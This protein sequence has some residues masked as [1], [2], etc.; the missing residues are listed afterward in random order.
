MSKVNSD[1]QLEALSALMDNQWSGS[2]SSQA[3]QNELLANLSGSKQPN[4]LLREK[5]E[6]Y[7][8]IRDVMHKELG[9]V[10]MSGFGQRVSDAI[11]K[12]PTIVSPARMV[13]ARGIGEEASAA[14]DANEAAS[15]DSVKPVQAGNSSDP[16]AGQDSVS[17]HNLDELQQKRLQKKQ[18]ASDEQNSSGGFWSGRVGAGVGGFAIA[19]SAAMVALL[20]FNLL[21][22]Q[23]QTN[24]P[25]VAG[26]GGEVAVTTTETAV[27]GAQTAGPDQ[28]ALIAGSTGLE[29]TVNQG[30]ALATLAPDA[31][32]QA[33]LPVADQQTL[34][35][36]R[37]SQPPIQFV[38]NA[39][40]FWVKPGQ[41][42]MPRNPALEKRLNQLLGKHIESSPTSRFGG[43]FPYS[44]LA[45]YDVSNPRQSGSTPQTPDSQSR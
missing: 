32:V 45:G 1:K 28:N 27:A 39:S 30:N 5:F 20:G 13:G 12:E 4:P 21:E 6:R 40:T 10:D 2:D 33:V 29:N 9:P 38:S 37:Q 41:T 43:M 44:R 15:P 24:N 22:Q 17:A 19:A 35:R 34:Q 3:D 8:L 36:I 26:V 18:L 14:A 7:H 42:D 25:L 31:G 11:A 23:D 16:L